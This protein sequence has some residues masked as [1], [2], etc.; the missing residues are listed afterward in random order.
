MQP[1][2]LD[3]NFKLHDALII[4]TGYVVVVCCPHKFSNKTKADLKLTQQRIVRCFVRFQKSIENRI[5]QIEQVSIFVEQIEINCIGINEC[6]KRTRERE[7]RFTKMAF[8]VCS[9]AQCLLVY[10]KL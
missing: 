2:K 9:A 8:Y 7:N 4:T 1:Q 10:I 3:G 5:V 6:S